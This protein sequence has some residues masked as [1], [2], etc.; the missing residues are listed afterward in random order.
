MA[1]FEASCQKRAVDGFPRPPCQMHSEQLRLNSLD[2]QCKAHDAAAC[3]SAKQLRLKD[4]SRNLQLL[5]ACSGKNA[6]LCTAELSKARAAADSYPASDVYLGN[7]SA[8]G[9][10]NKKLMAELKSINDVI[11]I[12]SGRNERGKQA[13]LQ[14]ASQILDFIPLIGTLKQ[15]YEVKT[16]GDALLAIASVVPEAGPT[17]AKLS[18]EAQAL[19]DAGKLDEAQNLLKAGVQTI[20]RN[21]QAA[22]K[23]LGSSTAR[24]G[25]TTG[26]NTAGTTVVDQ[27]ATGIKWGK[28]IQ[29]QR[30]PYEDFV[31]STLPADT[32]LPPNFKTFD[33]Y[34]SVTQTATSVKTL[35]TTTAAKIADPTQVYSALKSNVDAT[36][37]FTNY[38]RGVKSVDSSQISF[39]VVDVAIPQGTTS[40]QWTQINRA[41]DYA[42]SQGVTLKITVVKP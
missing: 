13:A 4:L 37:S 18:K 42:N 7:G 36:T 23:E 29:E 20:D 12:A 17:V 1:E 14:I 31:A 34:D 2:K 6:S 10:D 41:I 9:M 30:M 3:D 19:A 15:A 27:A 35:D 25:V 21:W 5:T 28:G 11:D 24:Q 26:A 38:T 22:T 39:R 8:S 16:L 40:A 33:F 32:R